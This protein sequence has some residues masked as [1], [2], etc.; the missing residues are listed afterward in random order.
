MQCVSCPRKLAVNRSLCLG[1]PILDV[2]AASTVNTAYGSRRPEPGSLKPGSARDA[3]VLLV[4]DGH[5]DYVDVI[6]EH[7]IGGPR[8]ISDD[9]VIAG[10]WWPSAH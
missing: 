6:G 4:K 10:R 9:V 2:I 8:I 7:L 1:I 5:F 3:T